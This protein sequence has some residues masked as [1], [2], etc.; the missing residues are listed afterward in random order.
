MEDVAK[1][2]EI[3]GAMF[4]FVIA[5]AVAFLVFGQAKTTSDTVFLA[6]DKTAYQETV[7]TDEPDVRATREV[8]IE[9]IIPMMYRYSTESLRIVVINK[10]GDIVLVL[11]PG[12]AVENTIG[13]IENNLTQDL[14]TIVNSTATTIDT[15]EQSTLSDQTKDALKALKL[16]EVDFINKIN[17]TMLTQD[18]IFRNYLKT[19]TSVN[20]KKPLWWNVSNVSLDLSIKNRVDMIVKGENKTMQINGNNYDINC[21]TINFKNYLNSKFDEY[22]ISYETSGEEYVPGMTNKNEIDNRVDET[23]ELVAVQRKKVIIYKE[24]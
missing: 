24:K 13:K 3:A 16:E 6:T 21:G 1:A 5:I 12:L 4:I 18:Q 9:T 20:I 2:L 15:S 14:Y 7:L 8:G 10:T 19:Y 17:H 11:D 22:Y 23:I